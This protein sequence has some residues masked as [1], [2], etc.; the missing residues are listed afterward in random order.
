MPI[1]KFLGSWNNVNF[2]SLCLIVKLAKFFTRDS[3]PSCG[4]IAIFWVKYQ[5][6]FIDL[7]L[8]FD[9]DHILNC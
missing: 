4:K 9:L 7:D 2:P 1:V 5:D 6:H 8:L 3:G